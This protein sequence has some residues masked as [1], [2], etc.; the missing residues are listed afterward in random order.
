MGRDMSAV[1][2]HTPSTQEKKTEEEALGCLLWRLSE[3]PWTWTRLSPSPRHRGSLNHL[4]LID[5]KDFLSLFFPANF[6]M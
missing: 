5:L 1:Q 2:H 3:T 6:C 4:F